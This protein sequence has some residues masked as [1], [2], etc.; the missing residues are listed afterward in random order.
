MILLPLS[1]IISLPLRLPTPL[2]LGP[3]LRLL[4]SHSIQV[5]QRTKTRRLDLFKV[6]LPAFTLHELS[7]LEYRPLVVLEPLL[8]I[9]QLPSC[10][11]V[12]QGPFGGLVFYTGGLQR[13]VRVC[14]CMMYCM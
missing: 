11:V 6:R 10:V 12:R 7:Y 4:D 8:C 9:V 14:V 3:P 13:Q 5:L 1:I 2:E